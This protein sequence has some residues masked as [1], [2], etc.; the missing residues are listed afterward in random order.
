VPALE[1]IATYLPDQRVPVEQV[2]SE[3]GLPPMQARLMRRFL[4]LG[5]V[6]MDPVGTLYDLLA[7]AMRNLAALRG[8]EEQVRYVLHARAIPVGVPYPANPLRALCEA[9]GLRH[10]VSFTVTHNACASGLLALHLAGRL[11]AQEADPGALVLVLAGEKAFTRDARLVPA[12][13]VFGEGSAACLVSAEGERDRVLSYASLTR[14]EFDGRLDELPELAARFE[15][16]YPELLA[17]ALYE[18]VK[19][20]GL[21]LDD[22]ALILPHNVNTMSWQ[23]LCRKIDFPVAKVL[24]ANTP[25]TGHVF[26]AD[27]FLNYRMAMTGGLLRPGDR[28]M[29][30]GAG[31]GATFAAMVV[32]H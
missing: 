9:F 28:Y 2:V 14:G 26:C 4:G 12:M 29:F 13:S 5:E 23:R 20:A 17:A 3:L 21:T 24:L 1:A 22:I 10:A 7:A 8:R 25:L 11:L 27:P 18:A 32:E 31:L 15:R 16:E 19:D 30:A 6:R